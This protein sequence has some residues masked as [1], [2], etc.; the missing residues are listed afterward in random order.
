[1][2]RNEQEA[3][4]EI[5]PH[6][7]IGDFIHKYENLIKPGLKEGN[8]EGAV[9]IIGDVCLRSEVVEGQFRKLKNGSYAPYRMALAYLKGIYDRPA[10]K[11]FSERQLEGL[12]LCIDRQV[13]ELDF[14]MHGDEVYERHRQRQTGGRRWK[15]QIKF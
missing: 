10:E 12:L 6:G 2:S 4:V 9:G 3:Q 5:N 15:Q 1:M 7:V 11:K 8:V 13:E 14:I